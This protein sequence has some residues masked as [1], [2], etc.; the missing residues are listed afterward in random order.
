MTIRK[1]SGRVFMEEDLKKEIIKRIQ[2][3]NWKKLKLVL[4]CIL[5]LED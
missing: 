5:N 1:N 2:K 3:F 4:I